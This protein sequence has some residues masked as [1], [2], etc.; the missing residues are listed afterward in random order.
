MENVIDGMMGRS[1]KSESEL[2]NEVLRAGLRSVSVHS[3]VSLESYCPVNVW[4]ETK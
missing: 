1:L 3:G 4:L 2:T